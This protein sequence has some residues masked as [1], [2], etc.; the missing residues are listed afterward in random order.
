MNAV[1]H[2]CRFLTACRRRLAG[3]LLALLT[4]L[5]W[6]GWVPSSFSDP[7][8]H[9]TSNG[10][11]IGV[12]WTSQPIDSLAIANLAQQATK[13]H[14]RYLFAFT[15]YLKA[16][17]SFNPSYTY[18]RAFVTA[19]R[20]HNQHTALL[21]WVGL[22]YQHGA[23]ANPHVRST[24]ISFIASLITTAGFDGV[25]INAEPIPN[26]DPHY[27]Q[28]L[29]ELRLAL[30]PTQVLS[31]ASLSWASTLE[32]LLLP[33]NPYRWTSSYY[34]AVA[35]RVDQIV[36][37]TYDSGTIVP[38]LYR[39]WMREQVRGIRRSV[40]DRPI[41]LLMGISLSREATSSHR[42]EVESLAN[43]LAGLCAGL[44]K[45]GQD[46]APISGVALYAFWEADA[47]DWHIWHS[48]QGSS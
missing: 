5:A 43:G 3:V 27:L 45:Q 47:S 13:Q 33:T 38:A 25:H 35:S 36:A 10:A 39:L 24:I 12:E 44:A 18:A 23:F 11:W 1:R 40:G 7:A 37:M 32:S 9:L 15:T 14:L 26:G 21:A 28:F 48:W 30:A 2:R 6:W 29:D 16:D 42:P 46:G 20:Q 31:V 17:R 8:C 19:F 22:P 34:H 41:G 4:V